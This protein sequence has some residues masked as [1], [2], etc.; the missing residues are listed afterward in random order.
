MWWVAGLLKSEGLA[1]SFLKLCFCFLLKSVREWTTSPGCHVS[2]LVCAKHTLCLYSG[3][4][5]P[6]L[7]VS[8]FLSAAGLAPLFSPSFPLPAGGTLLLFQPAGSSTRTAPNCIHL[9]LWIHISPPAQGAQN[10][11]SKQELD[12]EM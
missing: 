1:N 10:S 4:W 5:P 12:L 6:V 7:W 3:L 8:A 9:T 11:S 2:Q